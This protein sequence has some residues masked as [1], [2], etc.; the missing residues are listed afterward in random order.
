MSGYIDFVIEYKNGKKEI[1]VIN[2][3]GV[4]C[5]DVPTDDVVRKLMGESVEITDFANTDQYYDEM[6]QN[7]ESI[8]QEPT[9]P[10][11]HRREHSEKEDRQT[12]D[13]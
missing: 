12:L 8:Q 3:E 7:N 9:E 1:E 2:G 6:C 5:R 4:K 13:L 10:F 11:I